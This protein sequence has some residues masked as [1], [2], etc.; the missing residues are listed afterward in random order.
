MSTKIAEQNT[1]MQLRTTNK[2]ADNNYHFTVPYLAAGLVWGV[3]PDKF[4]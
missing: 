4:S 2:D 1:Q 3:H